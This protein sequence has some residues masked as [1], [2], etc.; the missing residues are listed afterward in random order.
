MRRKTSNLNYCIIC[1]RKSNDSESLQ[2]GWFGWAVG[3]YSTALA[4]PRSP[5]VQYSMDD[6]TV[7][8]SALVG[9]DTISTSV[10]VT[11]RASEDLA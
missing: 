1:S 6:E 5:T 7:N 9:H 3:C 8:P 4:R 11:Y 10:T 2:V